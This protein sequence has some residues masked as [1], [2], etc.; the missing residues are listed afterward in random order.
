MLFILAEI[1]S[2]TLHGDSHQFERHLGVLPDHLQFKMIW[3]MLNPLKGE[4]MQTALSSGL[5]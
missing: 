3:F 2:G 1:V 4:R 5:Q